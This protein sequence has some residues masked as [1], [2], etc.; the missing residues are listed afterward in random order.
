M[1][2]TAFFVLPLVLLAAAP[3]A[4]A[5]TVP[6][7]H[8]RSLELRGGGNVIVRPGP[9]QRVTILQGSSAYTNVRVDS[10]GRLK[11]DACNQRCPQHYDLRIEIQ[12][13][14]FPTSAV[15][16][17]GSIVAG[18]GFRPQSSV[19]VAVSGGGEIDT[20]ALRAS[21]VTAAVNG[22][23]KIVSGHS[24]SLTAAVNGGGEVRYLSSGN[25][26]SAIHGGGWVRP[27]G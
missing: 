19:T 9:V 21:N 14:D 24:S 8:F 2:C 11:I 7:Q 3:L 27:T 20:R 22:G 17:G 15:S 6:V 16:G 18:P 26:T 23:G 1:R 10:R 5:E 12:S 4:A 25:V 13:P